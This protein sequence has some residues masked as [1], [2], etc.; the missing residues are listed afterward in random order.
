[1]KS[2]KQKYLKRTLIATFIVAC[3]AILY[4]VIFEQYSVSYYE[5]QIKCAEYQ[6]QEKQKKLEKISKDLLDKLCA[7][8]DSA[9]QDVLYN[10]NVDC[11]AS[12]GFFCFNNGSLIFWSS[13]LPVRNEDLLETDTVEKFTGF[14]NELFLSETATD[15]RYVAKAYVCGNF[16]IVYVIGIITY[17]FYEND[18]LKS[19]FSEN[20]DVSPSLF[21]ENAGFYDGYTIKGADGTP[22]FVLGIDVG[23]NANPVSMYVRWFGIVLLLLVFV[24]AAAQFLFRR[25]IL[26]TA[27]S[28]IAIFACALFVVYSDWGTASAEFNFFNSS[29]YASSKFLTS[30]GVLFL[31]VCFIFTVI[32]VV[33]VKRR[34]ISFAIQKSN[35]NKGYIIRCS[36]ILFSVVQSVLCLLLPLTLTNDSN[37]SLDVHRIYDINWFTVLSYLLMALMFMG[38]A[39]LQILWMC[40]LKSKLYCAIIVLIQLSLAVF[41]L[42]LC[43]ELHIEILLFFAVY[44][45]FISKICFAVKSKLKTFVL[46]VALSTVFCVS[47]VLSEGFRKT[48]QITENLAELISQK[49]DPTFETMFAEISDKL[50]SDGQLQLYVKDTNIDISVILNY[51]G[52]KYFGGYF[53]SYDLHLNLCQ[54]KDLLFV[55]E[56]N[57]E[58]NYDCFNFFDGEKSVYGSR[59]GELPL[60]FIATG[61]GKI[62]YLAELLYAGNVETRLFL[63]FTSLSESQYI[64]YPELLLDR[65]NQPNKLLQENYYSYAKYFKNKLVSRYGNF[66]Y[67]YEL[68]IAK[69]IKSRSFFIHNGYIHYYIDNGENDSIIISLPVISPLEYISSNSFVFLFF[70]IILAIILRCIG[71]DILEIN[72]TIN[73]RQKTRILLLI[74]VLFLLVVVGGTILWHTFSQ[75][76]KNKTESIEEK[77]QMIK[78][79]FAL[80]Y[81]MLDDISATRDLS[82]W[83][84]AL[85]NLYHIDINIYSLD[86]KLLSTSRPEIFDRKLLGLNMN[87]QAFVNL[88][89]Q[90]Q[91][92]YMYY[93]NIGSLKFNS[94]YFAFY[95]NNDKK[96]VYLNLPYFE[97][98]RKFREEWLALANT[99][100]NIFI[101]VIIL[102]ILFA[103]VISNLLTKPLD[104]VRSQIGKFNLT[105]KSEHIKYKG[106]DEI[107]SLVSAYNSMLDKLAES[108]LKLAKTERE[109]AWREMAQQIAHE[110]KNPLT[111]MRLN[112]QHVMRLKKNNDPNWE[113]HFDSL[114][115]SLMEQISILSLTASEFSDFAKFANIE[116]HSVDVVELLEKQLTVFKGYEN[117]KISLCVDG[118]RPKTVSALYEQLQRVFTNLIKN[119]IQA[120]GDDGEGEIK[121]FASDLPNGCYRF[122]VQDSG[123]GISEELRKNLFQPNFTTKSS[124]TGLGLAIS[125]NIIENFGGRIYYSPSEDGKTC[126]IVELPEARN[127]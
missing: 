21:L 2:N 12:E 115:K 17:Y 108:A 59:V 38:F 77:I 35:V 13:S 11:N 20:F 86:G 75:F 89:A 116:R 114:A 123:T 92:Y 14:D 47:T 45:V 106:N 4:S 74:L 43:A 53:K 71:F 22:L 8:P 70:I 26:K 41:I 111:P 64:G 83:L 73:F 57:S 90:N 18:F 87:I 78:N 113:Q 46:F 27:L 48:K 105:G 3:F 85:S 102:G 52:E 124:G 117:I 103:T 96:L 119:A 100:I 76:E 82:L 98:Q 68:N 9:L 109:H 51:L 16:K 40:N 29:Y 79:E 63:S 34:N 39:M 97:H 110:I 62:N 32:C 94:I 101:V 66:G 50:L 65:K 1:M 58:T 60:W 19:R 80:R 10:I 61:N 93:D 55:T 15:N 6:I 24:I 104:T 36:L 81:G 69:K 95:N 49:N 72:R 112:I 125:K 25:S 30:F 7:A 5:N 37:F 118:V 121:L 33:F 67:G 88:N 127:H 84:I 122:K 99:V 91:P 23:E 120:I 42:I 28:I 126:F 107:G 31:Y 56:S 54:K 44:F